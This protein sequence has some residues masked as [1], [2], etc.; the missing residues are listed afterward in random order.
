METDAYAEYIE[1]DL[2]IEEHLYGDEFAE[3]LDE[4]DAEI[5]EYFG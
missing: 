1:E 4:Y 5:Q 3:Y 2:L